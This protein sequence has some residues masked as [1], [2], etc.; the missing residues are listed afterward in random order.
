MPE[1]TPQDV[2]GLS[3]ALA[4]LRRRLARLIDAA[5]MSMASETDDAPG[6]ACGALAVLG[7]RF[8]LS[9][10][11]REIVLLCA[12]AELD[13]SIPAACALAQKEPQRA[14]PTFALAASIFD[15]PSW[16]AF[17]P[18]GPLRHWRLIEMDSVEFTGT[19]TS[20]IRIAER[21]LHFLKGLECLDETLASYVAPVAP[22]FFEAPITAHL[23][24]A[25]R[26]LA[27][28]TSPSPRIVE[29]RGGDRRTR[30]SLAAWAAGRAGLGLLQLCV[31]DL[32]PQ[33]IEA[34]SF[35]RLWDRESILHPLALLITCRSYRLDMLPEEARKGIGVL[36]ER[37]RMPLVL[38]G[39]EA[40][41]SSAHDRAVIEIAHAPRHEQRALWEAVLGGRV[42]VDAERLTA[43]FD[44]EPGAIVEIAAQ[45][46]TASG[47]VE[48]SHLWSACL[49]RGRARLGRLA[50]RLTPSVAWDDLVLPAAEKGL[51]RR[52][53][54]QV[55]NRA[56]VYD[57]WGFGRMSQRGLGISALFHGESGTGKT[58]AA[59]VLASELA[60]DLY[61]IDLSQ[62]V[63]KYIGETEKNIR[64]VFDAA[65]QGGVVLFFDEADALFGRRSEVKDSHDRYANIE[66]SYL[67]QRME[68]YRGLS[69]LATNR[70]NALDPAFLRRLRFV[71]DFPFP[72]L[73]EA[74]ALW[75][76]TFP[77][78]APIGTLDLDRLAVL[79]LTGG[80][81]R[82]IA[83]NAAFLA[84]A[85]D[86]AIDMPVV[87]AAAADELRKLGRNPEE[88][89]TAIRCR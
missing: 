84:A 8:G 23:P 63:S 87:L 47:T 49:A 81:I 64:E 71:V 10:F 4:G 31:E 56:T 32:P 15:D 30:A 51:L 26:L 36:L 12:A 41:G 46:G 69:I 6:M 70:K 33:A 5:D 52:I 80:S 39:G 89:L 73:A 50:E 16:E 27:L 72:T 21:I 1:P 53:A 74:R 55:R 60:F 13:P 86:T 44:L 68:S 29:L 43:T 17:S 34:D 48:P 18:L 9:A 62:V 67:L 20:R 45:A 42:Q 54:T 75:M 7:D 22:P 79:G 2:Q 88:A 25:E 57:T 78:G 3:L 24:A 77:Q 61:R 19:L 58:L 28:L 11:E 38:D 76:R 66:I 40:D 65:E 83:M 85:A 14:Y 82:N 35:C 37:T 59:E